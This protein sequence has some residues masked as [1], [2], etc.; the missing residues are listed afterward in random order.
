MARKRP[1]ATRG[2]TTPAKAV[3]TTAKSAGKK[4]KVAKK[5]AVKKAAKKAAKKATKKVAEKAI[6]RA[7][8]TAIKQPAAKAV[9]SARKPAGKAA[10]E[11]AKP[12]APRRSTAR[13]S[14]SRRA[15]ARK[16]ESHEALVIKTLEAPVRA[17]RKKAAKKRRPP[18]KAAA[19]RPV[20][21]VSAKTARARLT[22]RGKAGASAQRGGVRTRVVKETASRPAAKTGRRP[23]FRAHALGLREEHATDRPAVEKLLVDAFGRE[24]EA[25]TVARLREDGD[26]V[27]ALVA[28][29]DGA[30]VGHVAFSRLSVTLDGR[31]IF[32]AALAP[33]AVSAHMR[34]R[35]V[36]AALVA[37]GLET[38]RA[39]G[40]AAVFVVGDSSYYA[41]FGFTAEAAG[42]FESVHAGETFLALAL[43][44]DVLRGESG[45]VTYP[46]ALSR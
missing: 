39:A 44:P 34:R 26:L 16:P 3:K 42:P 15:A 36:G 1:G 17:A 35:G 20:K 29:Y 2:G 24:D 23:P 4:A 27:G 45:A 13:I 8:K 18:V 31:A 22:S 28:E 14:A 43:E 21:T 32:A 38:A 40:A 5:A 7:S 30:I 33:L 11:V 12:P 25:R 46:S 6:E 37:A 19:T 9:K 41:R 10:G